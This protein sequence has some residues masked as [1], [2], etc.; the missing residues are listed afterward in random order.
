[1]IIRIKIPDN[2]Q[3][4]INEHAAQLTTN[5]RSDS[6]TVIP[7]P[8]QYQDL[9]H[10]RYHARSRSRSHRRNSRRDHV[11]AIQLDD[12]EDV[13]TLLHD[14]IQGTEVDQEVDQEVD[15][16]VNLDDTES[17]QLGV[18]NVNEE[19]KMNKLNN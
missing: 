8:D 10:N 11:D 13:D 15:P 7:D 9:I 4:N 12:I 14:Q 6:S 19:M 5:I 1:M 16:E 17:I 3:D 18:D 2:A